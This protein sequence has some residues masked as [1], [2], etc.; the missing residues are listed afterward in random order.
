M[1]KAALDALYTQPMQMLTS[2]RGKHT[3]RHATPD[4]KRNKAQMVA[5]H[6]EFQAYSA[7]ALQKIICNMTTNNEDY[8]FKRSRDSSFPK[9]GTIIARIIK[10]LPSSDPDEIQAKLKV[11][12]DEQSRKIQKWIR[13]QKS[14]HLWFDE[15]CKIWQEQQDKSSDDEPPHAQNPQS[16]KPQLQ[17]QAANIIESLQDH[18]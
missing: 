11:L 1:E 12:V 6:T 8:K 4:L 9:T 3:N 16:S 15:C 14:K 17:I 18:P 2:L 7:A 5:I 10:K 13:N